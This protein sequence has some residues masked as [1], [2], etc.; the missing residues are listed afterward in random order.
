MWSGFKLFDTLRNFKNV[1]FENN[2]QATISPTEVGVDP[3]GVGVN[4]RVH[5]A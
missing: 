4:V 1:N 2:D 5:V 3:V